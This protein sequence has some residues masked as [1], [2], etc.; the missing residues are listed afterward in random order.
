MFLILSFIFNLH[1]KIKLFFIVL[2]ILNS[3]FGTIIVRRYI[4]KIKNIT[5]FENDF[6]LLLFERIFHLSVILILFFIYK[7][8]KL[9]TFDIFL[10]TV[11]C[12]VVLNIYTLLFKEEIVYMNSIPTNKGYFI[13]TIVFFICYNLIYFYSKV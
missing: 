10:A 13:Y 5:G 7:I 8:P 1:S 3:I 11:S 4:N 9:V 2:A 6:M 12:F